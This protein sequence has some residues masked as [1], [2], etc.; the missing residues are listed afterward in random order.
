MWR[1]KAV[2]TS[3]ALK[4]KTP[5]T[6]DSGSTNIRHFGEI[7]GRFGLDHR[8]YASNAHEFQ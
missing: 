7:F 3:G 8:L 6:G 1:Q 4:I 5:G 2:I